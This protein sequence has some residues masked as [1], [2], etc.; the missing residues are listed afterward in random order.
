MRFP[1]LEV[2]VQYGLYTVKELERFAQGLVPKKRINVLSECKRCDFVY[3][4]TTCL[5]VRY[6]VFFGGMVPFSWDLHR[7]YL[8]FV[9][10]KNNHLTVR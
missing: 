8:P 4:G 10:G 9:F 3:D 7:K 2:M 6:E 1:S 5:I